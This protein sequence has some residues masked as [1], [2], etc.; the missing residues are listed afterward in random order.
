MNATYVGPSNTHHLACC[1]EFHG[2]RTKRYHTRVKRQVTGLQLVQ[3][4]E[5]LGL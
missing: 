4:P 1:I 2:A 3:V 5:H